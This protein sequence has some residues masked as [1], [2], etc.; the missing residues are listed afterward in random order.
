M[1]KAERRKLRIQHELATPAPW[2]DCGD[3]ICTKVDGHDPTVFLTKDSRPEDKEFVINLRNA[4]E[5]LLDYIDRLEA[6]KQ[7]EPRP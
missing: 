4:I 1:T 3:F 2:F 6:S 7:T 5:Q